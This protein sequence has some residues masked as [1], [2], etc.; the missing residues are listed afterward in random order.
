MSLLHLHSYTDIHKYMKTSVLLYFGNKFIYFLFL[1]FRTWSIASHVSK[2][3]WC[4]FFYQHKN[5][6]DHYQLIHIW[7]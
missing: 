1:R 6:T 7:H 3:V 2:H 5:K 4:D